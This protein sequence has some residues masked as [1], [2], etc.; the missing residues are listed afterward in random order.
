MLMRLDLPTLLRPMKATS[1]YSS[2]T[3]SSNIA[4]RVYRHEGAALIPVLASPEDTGI[5]HL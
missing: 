2:R 4:S 3:G 1:T 5:P